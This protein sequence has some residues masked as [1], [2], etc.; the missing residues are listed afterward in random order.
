[1]YPEIDRVGERRGGRAHGREQEARRVSNS[2]ARGL[3]VAGPRN[4]A[5][6]SNT[7]YKPSD[8]GTLSTQLSDDRVFAALPFLSS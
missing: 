1:M 2:D 4:N 6:Q 8:L 3:V 5:K 7:I